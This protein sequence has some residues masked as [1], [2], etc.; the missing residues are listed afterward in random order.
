MASD[1]NGNIVSVVDKTAVVIG[2]TS[3]IG[4]GIARGFAEDGADVIASSR[5]P[6]RVAAV[7]DELRDHGAETAALTCD[8]TDAASVE[9]L[10]DEVLDTFGQIDILVYAPSYIARQGVMDVEP[11][12]WESVFDV[13]L[14]GA[15]RATQCF[16]SEMDTGSIIHIA[17]A[18]VFCT[19]PNVA[20]YACAKGG[21][22]VLIRMAARELGPA[23]RVNGIRPGFIQSE[24]TEGT[25]TPGTPRFDEIARRT[26]NGRLGTPDE[27]VGCAI[28][29]GSDATSY[30]TGEIIT[31]DDGFIAATFV[32]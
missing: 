17:S 27:L 31:I 30:L 26:T 24:Q 18:S 2:G 20:A 13:Q 11:D 32:E 9:A 3:G 10:R 21:L 28:L 5:T 14:T 15:L 23:I 22:D 1:G 16:A 19:I 29:L 12:E 7:A 6:D 8:A 25:Y 4:R